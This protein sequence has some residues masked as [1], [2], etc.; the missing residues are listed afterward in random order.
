MA[1][2]SSGAMIIGL[3]REALANPRSHL[4]KSHVVECVMND[5][6]AT[7]T[8]ALSSRVRQNQEILDRRTRSKG[9]SGHNLFISYETASQAEATL[10]VSQ[11]HD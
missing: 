4:E 3:P 5:C 8:F 10:I 2:D 7:Q 9:G 11:Q 1:L 6:S